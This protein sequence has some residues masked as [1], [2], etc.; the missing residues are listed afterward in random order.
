MFLTKGCLFPGQPSWAPAYKCIYWKEYSNNNCS[1]VSVRKGCLEP[2]IVYH[3]RYTF[4]DLCAKPENSV[5]R[6]SQFNI[7]KFNHI[8]KDPLLALYVV[9][10]NCQILL[11]LHAKL[12]T[13]GTGFFLGEQQS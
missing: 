9:Q 11:I 4:Y 7:F 6:R 13:L 3:S 8:R 2:I 5:R 1:F 10:C 12:E